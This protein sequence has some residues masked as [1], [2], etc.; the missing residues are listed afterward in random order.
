M[1]NLATAKM[2]DYEYNVERV[3]C[4]QHALIY[5]TAREMLDYCCFCPTALTDSNTPLTDPN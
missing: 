4:S 1:I 5:R 3:T 2:L